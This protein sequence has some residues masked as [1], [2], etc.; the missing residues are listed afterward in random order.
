MT[1]TGRP[2][3][4]RGPHNLTRDQ[5]AEDQR[6]RLIEAMIAQVADT[7]YAPCTVAQIIAR[8]QVSRKTFYV[9]FS[10]REDLMLT[11]FETASTWMLDQ[12]TKAS[13][14]TGGSTRRLEAAIRKLA[15]CA[16]ESPGAIG[17][18]TVDVAAAGQ[19]GFQRRQDV[20]EQMGV[21]LDDCLST[22][23]Q[24]AALPPLLSAAIAGGIYRVLDGQLRAGQ[25][26]SLTNTALELA[27]WVRSYHPAPQAI[28]EAPS[29]D[30]GR[31]AW[32]T[33]DGYYG[34]RAPGTLTL[35]SASY[36]P[37]APKVSR[38]YLAHTN[39]ERI[40]DAVARLTAEHGYVELTAQSIATAADLSERAFLAHFAS[41]D[42]AFA[43]TCELGHLKA[44]A[45]VARARDHAPTWRVGV[46]DA[47]AGLLDFFASEPL[48]TNLAIVA[49]PL[50]GPAMAVRHNEQ[51]AAYAQLLFHDAPQRRR[52]P[53]IAGQAIAHALF[54][55]AFVYAGRERVAQLPEALTQATYL[56]LAPYLGAS[57]AAKHATA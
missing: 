53:A 42:E 4:P 9:Y 39:R 13:N 55:M 44:Q 36:A 20:I 47:I 16:E 15:R 49:A 46:Q 48:Y 25:A 19:A 10:S 41:K 22:E 26:D 11:A 1:P 2:T 37:P 28:A 5:V 6:R 32:P 45:I 34:G 14:R 7:G 8:A 43:A 17:L 33:L 57:E 52:P 27:R 35:A 31:R 40:L 56:A 24:P 50:A 21:L 3:L 38:S 51:V 54:E 18:C 23:H 30:A 12:T 29:Q